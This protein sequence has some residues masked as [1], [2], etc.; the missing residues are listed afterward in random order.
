MKNC[1]FVDHTIMLK[2]WPWSKNIIECIVVQN[3]SAEVSGESSCFFICYI[4]KILHHIIRVVDISVKSKLI[5][6]L[7]HS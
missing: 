3:T 4:I 1:L 7:W 2:E 6:M 5:W